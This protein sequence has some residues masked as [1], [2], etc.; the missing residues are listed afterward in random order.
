MSSSK[1]HTMRKTILFLLATSLIAC[2]N[3][4][5][6]ASK[7]TPTEET[8]VAAMSTTDLAYP[9]KDW[10]D[11]QPGSIDNL[12]MVLQALKDFENGNIDASLTSFADSIHLSFDQMEGTFSKDSLRKMFTAQ[13][14]D[15][16]SMKIYMDDYESVKSKDGKQQYV[17]LWYK[18]IWE[19][20]KGNTDSIEQ[21]NDLRIVNGKIASL[22]EKSRRYPKKKM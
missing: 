8:K 13:R 15:L 16:K 9:L 3:S 14:S 17:S 7:Q 18:Q 12:K 4:E 5:S 21:M 20:K 1:Q 11:W 19:D 22:S 10:A 6:T 2:N